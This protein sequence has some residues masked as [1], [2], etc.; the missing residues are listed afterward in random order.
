MTADPTEVAT[1]IADAVTAATGV[2]HVVSSS[3]TA[4]GRSAYVLRD[5]PFYGRLYHHPQVRVSDHGCGDRTAAGRPT[6]FVWTDSTSQRLS[7]DEQIAR[8]TEVL[9]A[10]A[11]YPVIG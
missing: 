6:T 8:A 4:W 3:A 7:L 2:P 9:V 1:A 5:H 10:A 11:A